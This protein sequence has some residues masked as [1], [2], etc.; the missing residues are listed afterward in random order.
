[1]LI[2][3]LLLAC[4]NPAPAPQ[5]APP[6]APSSTPTP[7][8]P[9][10]TTAPTTPGA[11]P[12]WVAEAVAEALEEEI[13]PGTTGE[14]AP[15]RDVALTAFFIAHPEY[16]NPERRGLLSRDAC[17]VGIEAAHARLVSPPPRTPH[18]VQV[19]TGDWRVVAIHAEGL[20]TSDDWGWF[21]SE[22]GE[23]LR[24]LGVVVE[25]TTADNDVLVVQVNGAEVARAPLTDDGYTALRPGKAP[26][27]VGHAPTGEVLPPVKAYFE[28]P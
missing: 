22:V 23:A 19:T 21:T 3:A 9:P 6:T 25:G 27:Q 1:M 28:L 26:L 24:P 17:A 15:G 14:A 11:T 8:P 12:A 4:G 20:C 13:Q 2:L 10:S 7:P 5:A 16:E 18:V